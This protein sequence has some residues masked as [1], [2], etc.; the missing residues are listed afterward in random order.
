MGATESKLAFRKNVFALYE[1]RNLNPSDEE[2]WTKFYQLPENPEDVF[3]LFSMKDIRKVRDTAPENLQT[4]IVKVSDRI[5]KFLSMTTAPAKDDIRDCLN[6][7]RILIRVLPFLFEPGQEDLEEKIFWTRTAIEED[8]DDRLAPRLIRAVIQLLFFKGLTLPDVVSENHGTR[9]VIWEKGVGTSNAPPNSAILTSNRVELLRL[10]MTMLSGT[11]YMGTSEI[12]K[13]PNK[14]A[15]VLA[16]GLDKKSVLTLLC[17]L[18]NTSL[19][20]DP[21]GWGLIPYNH[22]IFGDSSEHYVSLCIQLL[23]LILDLG[24]ASQLQKRPSIVVPNVVSSPTAHE[25]PAS[26]PDG[27][28]EGLKRESTGNNEFRFYLAK[29]HRN[30]DFVFIMEGFERLLKNPIEAS[31]TY[32]PGST[33]KLTLHVELI[34]LFWKFYEI[35]EKFA[36]YAV[37]SDEILTVSAALLH[38]CSL[39]KN[40][41]NHIGII[42]M[43]CFIL[44]VLSQERPFGVQLNTPFDT[45]AMAS[46]IKT[47]PLFSN[48]TW[49][50]FFILNARTD[51][52]QSIHQLITTTGKSPIASL[53]EN[54][55]I[56]IANVSPFIKS[57]TVVSAN[58]LLNI[59]HSFSNPGFMLAN[60]TNHK[61]VFYLLDIFNNIVQYQITGNSHL[62]YAIVRSRQRFH[63]LN[64]MTFA[65][66]SEELQR[67][68]QAKAERL[69]KLEKVGLKPTTEDG[70]LQATPPPGAEGEAVAK[71]EEDEPSTATSPR[72][73][74]SEKAKGKLPM[75]Q[76]SG[77]TKMKFEPTEEW[78]VY[79]K[80]HLRLSVLI[81]LVDALGP[82]IEALCVEKGFND[83]RRVIEY[84]Q[85]GTLVGLLPLPHPLFIRRFSYSEPVRIWFTSYMW[86]HIFV[87]NTNVA[88]GAEVVKMNPTIWAGTKLALFNV[89]ST[90]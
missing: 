89:K 58:K 23:T 71:V 14:W 1:Q 51:I 61:N 85:S 2:Y 83:D 19:S 35:N 24:G 36:K 56:C 41:P 31:N 69:K 43:S 75:S 4:I 38:F 80:S 68:R 40:D 12:L 46:A 78:F 34:M 15:I 10:L 25:T 59:F 37:E 32:L 18:I 21:I 16:T 50:D 65:T 72:S 44:H 26:F 90:A 42:R 64:D 57:L 88:G 29:L 39:S 45:G 76:V 55:L 66:A 20:Y 3:N 62:V 87:K 8:V 13:K 9:F 30:E 82:P 33:K 52:S 22:V 28:E 54:L 77:E 47:L 7:C 5:F 53:H 73:E 48:G 27:T 60:E 49:A 79:W 86:G 81:T 17:S 6:C 11:M 84:L 63:E 70:A 74:M 67:I